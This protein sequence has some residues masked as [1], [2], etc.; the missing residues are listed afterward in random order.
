MA[1]SARS[2]R[3]DL[4]APS[5]RREESKD[6]RPV[7]TRSQDAGSYGDAADDLDTSNP[8]QLEHLIGYGASYPNSVL[9]IPN[10]DGLF[11]KR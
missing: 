2:N 9:T 7:S 4:F 10:T 5:S 3:E 6:E 11:I 1:M 8:L